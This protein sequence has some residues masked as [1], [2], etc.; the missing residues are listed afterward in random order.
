VGGFGTGINGIN[1]NGSE[2]GLG[3]GIDVQST[4]EALAEAAS[5]SESVYTQE[6]SQFSSEASALTNIS[7]LLS[8]LQTSIQALQYPAGTMA[9]RVAT[10]SDSSVV[11]AAPAAGVALSTYSV[12]VSSLALTSTYISN[13]LSSS[14]SNVGDGTLTYTINGTQ[15]NITVSALD[16]NDTLQS[17]ADYI[18]GGNYGVTAA[19]V[20]QASGATLALTS[21]TSGQPGEIE[22]TTNTTG[23]DLTEVVT[24]TNA[25]GTV[26]GIPVSSTT[27]TV[28]GAFPGVTFNFAGIS[29]T[30]VTVTVTPDVSQ[31]ST[32]INNFVSAY[33]SVVQAINAQLTYT[34][35]AS[36]QPPL[37]SDASVQQAQEM[38]STDMNYFMSSNGTINSLSAMGVSLQQDGTLAVDSDTLNSVLSS[39]YGGVQSFLQGNGSTTGF[40]NQVS[41]DLTTLNAPTV[42]VLS[43][44][45]Q[46]VNQQEQD[47]TETIN[48]FNANLTQEEQQWTLEYSQ[49]NTTLEQL[50]LLLAQLGLS[51][52]SGSS[53]G[54][55]V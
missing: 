19:V 52:V 27:N 38:L 45:L 48:D 1:L 51:S 21:Q 50:P 28:T 55:F 35:G 29:S 12:V 25:T 43:L 39:D 40:A 37:F 5:A 26:D 32:A 54:D 11:T 30:P 49:V 53:S 17:L 6:Q 3:S 8:S 16:A 23:L 20:S 7:S 31:A 24:G 2:F 15:Y 13:T 46:G 34:A 14:T 22:I 18:N 44:D 41:N 47:V 42:G 33:N 4:V 9:A 36:S 10:S